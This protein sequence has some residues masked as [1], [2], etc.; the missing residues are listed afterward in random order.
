MRVTVDIPDELWQTYTGKANLSTNDAVTGAI[1]F[2]CNFRR[3]AARLDELERELE[4]YKL[5][6]AAMTIDKIKHHE[7]LQRALDIQAQL[8]DQLATWKQIA[9]AAQ[10]KIEMLERRSPQLPPLDR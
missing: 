8:T 5:A 2:A 3:V 6:I 4:R 7:Q 9:I 1:A 10:S